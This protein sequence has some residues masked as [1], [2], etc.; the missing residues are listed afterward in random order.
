MAEEF[1]LNCKQ[2]LGDKPF[3]WIAFQSNSLN[4]RCYSTDGFKDAFDEMIECLRKE[5][6]FYSPNLTLNMRN[7]SEVGNLAK[8][9]KSEYGDVEITN[10]IQS[11]PTP[12]SSITSTKPTLF[13]V[14][15]EDFINKYFVEFEKAIDEGKIN[16]ILISCTKTFD[17]EQIKEAL[18][19]CDIV[20]EDIFIHTLNSN[21]SKEDIKQFLSKE[22]GF[23]I[24][25]DELFTGMEADSIL[26]CI[27]DFDDK[28]LR[29]NV[30]RACSKLNIVYCY[31]TD[32]DEYIDFSGAKLDPTFMNGCDEEMKNNAFQ[33]LTCQKK[34]NK[35]EDVKI[36]ED[37]IFVCK[38]CLIGC[39]SGHDVELKY[40]HADLEKDIVKCDCK[41]KCLNCIFLKNIISSSNV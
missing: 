12:K 8:S 19:E 17:V 3:L 39:H 36:D 24:C 15:F 41:T 20:E 29:V 14:L 34:E 28:N 7:S 33:C 21:N 22:K 6:N 11:L 26:Y 35:N 13:P 9:L 1:I 5:L 2:L 18:V 16:V 38:P 25:E 4:D 30:M 31:R 27:N 40:V 37:D 23:L 32:Y 10:V